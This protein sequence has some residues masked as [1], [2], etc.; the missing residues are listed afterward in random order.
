MAKSSSLFEA[1]FISSWME[2][3]GNWNNLDLPPSPHEYPAT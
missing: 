2:W 1:K 3:D